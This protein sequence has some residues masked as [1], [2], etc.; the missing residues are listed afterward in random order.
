MRKSFLEICAFFVLVVATM[1][2]AAFT[3]EIGIRLINRLL[4][5]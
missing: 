2:V 1:I 5:V 3:W 4:P